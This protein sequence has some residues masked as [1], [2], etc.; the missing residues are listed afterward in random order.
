MSPKKT[1]TEPPTPRPSSTT[2]A[3]PPR[4]TAT[5]PLV[6]LTLSLGWLWISLS[7]V[8]VL[9]VSLLNHAPWLLALARTAG[10]MLILGFLVWYLSDNLVRALLEAQIALQKRQVTS[11]EP[12]QSTREINA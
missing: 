1:P 5:P 7:G 4:L 3:Q 11:S 9:V 2:T 8:L 12:P 6:E 10:V